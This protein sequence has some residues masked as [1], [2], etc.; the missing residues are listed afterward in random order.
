MAIFRI[1]IVMPDRRRGRCLGLFAD[2]FEA[3][4]Q[5][6]ADYPEAASVSALF[7]KESRA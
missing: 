4:A 6:M 2:A 1:T 7:I 5:T 3:V